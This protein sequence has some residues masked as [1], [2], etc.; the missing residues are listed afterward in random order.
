MDT[1]SRRAWR[2]VVIVSHGCENVFE[3][4]QNAFEAAENLVHCWPQRPGAAF[5]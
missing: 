3:M 2:R 5:H 4:V 1:P